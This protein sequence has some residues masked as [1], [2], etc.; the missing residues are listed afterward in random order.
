MK[1]FFYTF[2]CKVNQYETENIKEAMLSEGYEVTEDYADAE[3][4]VV[5]TC[6][7]TAQ[8][9][10][11]C[12]QLIHKIKKANPECLIV[13]AGCFPQAFEKEASALDECGIIIGTGAKKEIPALIKRYITSGERII[14]IVPRERGEAFEKM[15]NSGADQ[16]TRAYIKIQ[17]GCDQYCTYCIIPTARGHICSKPLED[18]A[19]E[20][21]QLVDSGHKEIIL[22]GINLCCYGRDFK[23]G[24]RLIDAVEAACGCDGDYRVRIG[25]VEPELIS[26]ED[27]L[28]MSKL[29]KLCPHL[30]P[31]RAYLSFMSSLLKYFY[32]SALFSTKG[33]E[34]FM[35]SQ[36]FSSAHFHLRHLYKDLRSKPPF[37]N[38]LT[39]KEPWLLG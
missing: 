26:D 37:Y 3:V 36:S 27:I 32:N 6:T 11:K 1:A 19:P 34:L 12:R 17:D 28:R 13:L 30:S 9:D 22:T 8:S 4:C 39:Y 31:G 5:N 2:G 7:V 16:K 33:Q 38:L 21:Q 15:T 24:T 23:N 29:E 35:M 10:S 25:S 14:R 18:I 20:V